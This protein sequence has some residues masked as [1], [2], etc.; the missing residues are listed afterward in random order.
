MSAALVHKFL[1]E[2]KADA[3]EFGDSKD[4]E[5][6]GDSKKKKKGGVRILL[7]PVSHCSRKTKQRR[8]TRMKMTKMM[9]KAPARQVARF[10]TSR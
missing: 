6:P 4:P 2:E 1:S 7:V 8:E 5:K 9:K 10:G 3:V